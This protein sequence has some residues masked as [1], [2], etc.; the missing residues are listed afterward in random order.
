[1][2]KYEAVLEWTLGA[3]SS[4]VKRPGRECERE[5][6]APCSAYAS[7]TFTETPLYF[8]TNKVKHH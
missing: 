2:G 3:V 1:M 8:K 4:G 5:R 6:E 7:M